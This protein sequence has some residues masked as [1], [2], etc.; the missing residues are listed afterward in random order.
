MGAIIAGL[1]LLGVMGGFYLSH[2]WMH[3]DFLKPMKAA[4]IVAA[5]ISTL[6]I[7]GG[8]ANLALG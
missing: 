6:L 2:S 5:I 7:L 8:V 3:P 1:I 4:L